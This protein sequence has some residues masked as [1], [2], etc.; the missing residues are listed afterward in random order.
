MKKT[1]PSGL[2]VSC[3]AGNGEVL[4]DSKIMHLFAKCAVEGG[5]VAIRALNDEVLQ[6]KNT[7]DVPVI[8]LVKRDYLDSEVYITPTKKEIDELLK[9]GCDIIALDAT[10]RK[11]PN[12][13]SLTDLVD[14]IKSKSSKVAIMAD[15][16]EVEDAII[17]DNLG[18]DYVSTTLR[19][20]TKSTKHAILPDVNFAKECKK[21]L[22]NAKLIV[23][24]GVWTTEDVDKALQ[25]VN[26]HA[27]VIGTAITRPK[28]ITERFVKRFNINKG[29]EC[30]NVI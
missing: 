18:I 7:V 6:I 10:S 26:P 4:H 30:E 3:Q 13:E 29:L 20:Y 24:G 15:I 11:R 21:L 28:D 1:I 2:I 25:V 22:K 19:G 27:I 16:A 14:Y 12:G 17:A 9:N 5:A 23:E 8:G